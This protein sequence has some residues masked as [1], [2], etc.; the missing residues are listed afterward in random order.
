MFFVKLS[1]QSLNQRSLLILKNREGLNRKRPRICIRLYTAKHVKSCDNRK[2][3]GYNF[4]YGCL[5][6]K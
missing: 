1:L 3:C 4:R 5:K 2:I 6:Y